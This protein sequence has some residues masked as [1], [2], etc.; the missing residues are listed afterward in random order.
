MTTRSRDQDSSPVGSSF[1]RMKG[2][3]LVSLD[4]NITKKDR[5]MAA[6]LA[7]IRTTD[8]WNVIL[9]AFRPRTFSWKDVSAIN[10]PATDKNDKILTDLDSERLTHVELQ[11]MI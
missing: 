8:K 5:E 7:T 4:G 3:S 9:I 10:V 6:N 1:K 11:R 2:K